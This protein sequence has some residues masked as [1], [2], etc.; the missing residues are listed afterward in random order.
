MSFGFGPEVDIV[1]DLF[2]RQTRVRTERCVRPLNKRRL[3][4]HGY[5]TTG[6]IHAW[7][8]GPFGM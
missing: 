8:K 3:D 4:D 7:L 2:E 6:A 5:P 1:F